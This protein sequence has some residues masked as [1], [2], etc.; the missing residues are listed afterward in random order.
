[1]LCNMYEWYARPAASGTVLQVITH[2]ALLRLHG[3]HDAARPAT[4]S[5]CLFVFPRIAT[6]QDVQPADL[7]TQSQPSMLHA[8]AEKRKVLNK[9]L[10]LRL[11]H[12]SSY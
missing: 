9:H 7:A 8:S 3:R 6:H 11:R 1:M 5:R 4:E 12:N 2:E 10:Q